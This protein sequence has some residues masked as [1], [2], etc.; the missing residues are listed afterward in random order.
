MFS[1]R[2]LKQAHSF[3]RG[4]STSQFEILYK[5]GGVS[6]TARIT[7]STLTQYTLRNLQFEQNYQITIRARMRYSTYCY[8]YFYGEYSNEVNITT[9]ETGN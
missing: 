7:S 9:M 1:F 4:V 2:F 8:S 6:Y 3:P 5:T